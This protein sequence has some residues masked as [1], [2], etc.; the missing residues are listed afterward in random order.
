[1]I[2]SCEGEEEIDSAVSALQHDL[3]CKMRE[4]EISQE[5]P[6]QESI[7]IIPPN[8]EYNGEIVCS[9]A[10]I[11]D[12]Q[13]T[14]DWL[15]NSI[16]IQTLPVMES[17]YCPP[18]PELYTYKIC[19]EMISY[20]ESKEN[21]SWVQ[22]T[23]EH[24]APHMRG[25]FCTTEEIDTQ[26]QNVDIKADKTDLTEKWQP[27]PCAEIVQP[28]IDQNKRDSREMIS[29]LTPTYSV[30]TPILST[31]HMEPVDYSLV[32]SSH[33]GSQDLSNCSVVD[34]P[35]LNRSLRY[36]E[37]RYP[38]ARGSTP[39]TKEEQRMNACRRERV[40]MKAMNLAFDALRS[41]L[42]KIK[43]RGRKFSK[44][45]TLSNWTYIRAHQ[46]TQ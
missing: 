34:L 21:G 33:S 44:I 8:G 32:N 15:A 41:K 14:R 45:E 5:V 3:R 40:R 9:P 36:P 24:F 23:N 6:F 25:L 29:Q 16:N 13:Y 18:H 26:E 35:F 28:L 27:K 22:L 10:M 17:V 30:M 2:S 37:V 1:M 42:E 19:P 4:E 11:P 20:S 38:R 31:D 12:N 43:P 46:G 7:H 39:L